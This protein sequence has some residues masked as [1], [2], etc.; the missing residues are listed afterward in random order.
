MRNMK[1]V[2]TK[3]K[4]LRNSIIPLL[5][6][7]DSSFIE[8]F[9]RAKAHFTNHNYKLGKGRKGDIYQVI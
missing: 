1:K 6:I 5:L 9:E 8:K 7:E 4:V 3:D 2:L